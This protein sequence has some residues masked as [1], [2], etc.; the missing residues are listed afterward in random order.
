MTAYSSP[1]LDYSWPYDLYL[2]NLGVNHGACSLEFANQGILVMAY[3]SKLLCNPV[4]PLLPSIP[5]EG[6]Y[7]VRGGQWQKTV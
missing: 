3:M 6:V 4:V 7:R 2:V 5:A 1:C